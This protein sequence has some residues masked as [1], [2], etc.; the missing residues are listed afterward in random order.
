MAH[1]VISLKYR[2]QDFDELTGQEHIIRSLKGALKSGSIGHAFL[3]AGPRGVGKTTMA[4]IFAKSLNCINGP[5]IHP[6]QECQA[7][8]EITKSRSVD[9][10]EID[11]A[12]NRGIDEI[13]N[14]REGIKYSPLHSRY[15]VYIIDE[16]HMLTSEAFNAL[17]KTL[18]E[19][20][21]NVVFILA[22]TNPAKIPATILSRCQRFIFKRLSISEITERL[23]KIAEK[24][25]IRITERALYY[26]ALRADGSIRDGESILEQLSSF[27]EGEITEE[28]VFKM[29]GLLAND[30]Y[31]DLLKRISQNDLRG[32][33]EELNR[34]VEN[35][36]DPLEI[37]RGLVGF[38]RKAMLIHLGLKQD[39]VDSSNEEIELLRSIG[40]NISHII[41]MLETSLKFEDM[42]KRSINPRIAIELLFTQLVSSP[43]PE[44]E[45][46][47]I[48]ESTTL[49]RESLVSTI[50]QKSPRLAA[51]IHQTEVIQRG[52][53]ITLNVKN[54]F[55]KRELLRHQPL[56]EDIIQKSSGRKWSI[57]IQMPELPK[58]E[59]SIIQTIKT[60]FDGEEVR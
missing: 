12:S 45:S 5:T 37:Y 19:P 47:N 14:L 22:T 31:L 49:S 26:L 48:K 60:M 18:E 38:L 13:R 23:K 50:A 57:D 28:D 35:G 39:F 40:L 43:K 53:V 8:K 21:V 2:P 54:E 25:G 4:R 33:I 1:R 20:P 34:A 41:N 17:L 36:A 29:T 42:I 56:L 52:D 46:Q 58:K 24:E 10:I 51:I 27:V 44:I 32:M 30:F 15:K 9:V 55:Q 6:C 11:G 59:D 3:F 7:C 16:V